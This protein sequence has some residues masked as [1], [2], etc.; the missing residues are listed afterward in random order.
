M[1]RKEEK[2][3]QIAI[4][5]S[6]GLLAQIDKLAEGEQRNRSNMIE[7]ILRDFFQGLEGYSQ[8]HRKRPAHAP[9]ASS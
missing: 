8:N 7:W 1:N 5:L 3:T 9:G 4:R 2:R 6:A